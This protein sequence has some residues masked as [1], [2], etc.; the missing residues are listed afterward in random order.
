[1]IKENWKDVIGY[2][3]LYK[4]SDLRRVKSLN[5]H[6][7]G[8]EVILKQCKSKDGYLKV[9][10]FKNGKQTTFSVHRI[11]ALAF[12]NNYNNCPEINH[13]DEDKT[14]NCVENLEW[15]DRKYNA[16]YGTAKER[17]IK[18]KI[19]NGTNVGSKKTRNAGENNPNS[20]LKN[21]DVI[22]I[23]ENYIKNHKEFGGVALAKK[24]GVRRE[25]IYRIIMNKRRVML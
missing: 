5:Y 6:R 24:F 9:C 8:K 19:K 1:M 21:S 7:S 2:E 13:K 10:L 17:I 16:N 20:K 4:V 18:T 22:F 3:G 23:R 12:I 25:C 14:N 15:C 11:V